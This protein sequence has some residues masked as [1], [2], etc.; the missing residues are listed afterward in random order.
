MKEDRKRENAILETAFK[1]DG[2]LIVRMRVARTA[3]EDF[4]GFCG[5]T[6]TGVVAPDHRELAYLQITEAA[7]H[8]VMRLT[9]LWFANGDID[10][11]FRTGGYPEDAHR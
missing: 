2:Q 8:E 5:N 3:F 10:F 9:W 11:R 6:R 4:N 7:L 1:A